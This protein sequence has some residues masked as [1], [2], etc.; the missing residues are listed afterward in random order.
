MLSAAQY[1]G[2]HKL[3]TEISIGYPLQYMVYLYIIEY[4]T[5]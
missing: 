1:T 5:L 4:N 3:I 2:T